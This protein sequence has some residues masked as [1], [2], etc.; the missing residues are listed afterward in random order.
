MNEQFS[1]HVEA[2]I[3]GMSAAEFDVLTETDFGGEMPKGWDMTNVR[4]AI[5]LLKFPLPPNFPAG[6]LRELKQLERDVP[7]PK[8]VAAQRLA[9]WEAIIGLI[10]RY[11]L[12]KKLVQ[13]SADTDGRNSATTYAFGIHMAY[14]EVETNA[15][16]HG[17][18]CNPQKV[19]TVCA[20]IHDDVLE[21]IIEDQG[22]GFPCPDCAEPTPDGFAVRGDV[23]FADVFEEKASGRG[24]RLTRAFTDS[25]EYQ[26]GGT[27]CVIR[28][29]LGDMVTA[30]GA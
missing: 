1:E 18:K 3:G 26:R 21:M 23:E 22:R 15:L 24:L 19:V 28:K 27:R 20:A 7:L 10:G 12:H 14:D 6:V 8:V 16:R 13:D 11:M 29:N 25:V 5:E 30:E 9:A 2:R 17:N 4:A